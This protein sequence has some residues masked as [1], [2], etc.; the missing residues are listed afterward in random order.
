MIF[1]FLSWRWRG[2]GEGGSGLMDD[3][4]VF[5]GAAIIPSRGA[6]A[7]NYTHCSFFLLQ[8]RDKLRALAC[9][10]VLYKTLKK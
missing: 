2:E 9:G 6:G 4:V 10:K 5:L 3:L 8:N 7:L 1:V